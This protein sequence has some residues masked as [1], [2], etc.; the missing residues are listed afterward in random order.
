MPGKFRDSCRQLQEQ[1]DPGAW[2]SYWDFMSLLTSFVAVHVMVSKSRRP[3]VLIWQS[4]WSQQSFRK[5]PMVDCLAWWHVHVWAHRYCQWGGVL[6]P[7]KFWKWVHPTCLGM[8]VCRAWEWVS[9]KK[10]KFCYPKMGKMMPNL[11]TTD[12]YKFIEQRLW[13]VCCALTECVGSSE[14]LQGNNN[15]KPIGWQVLFWAL[16]V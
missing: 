1:L 11:K 16:E 7:V 8:R 5:E 10:E 15:C 14:T 12:V 9:Q 4:G 13:A 2:W 3:R 6:W